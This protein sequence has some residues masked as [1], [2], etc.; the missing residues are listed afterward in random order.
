M[1]GRTRNAR[2]RAVVHPRRCPVR[3]VVAV[4][5]GNCRRRDMGQRPPR[6]PSASPDVAGCAGA[7]SPSERPGGMAGLAGHR[8]VG[9]IEDEPGRVVVEIQALRRTFLSGLPQYLARHADKNHGGGK[10]SKENT[11]YRIQSTTYFD[12]LPSRPT[13]PTRPEQPPVLQQVTKADTT[14]S[15]AWE[16]ITQ[17]FH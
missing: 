10:Q 16:F 5:A 1:A 3:G 12:W 15:G 9:V 8:S 6:R 17:I 4:L 11:A 2:C 7:R 13:A 14:V